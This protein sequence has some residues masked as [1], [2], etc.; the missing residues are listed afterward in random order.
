MDVKKVPILPTLVTLANAFCGFAAIIYI[1]QA[2]MSGADQAAVYMKYAGW[3]IILA[4]VFDALDGKVARL[5]NQTSE[6][7]VQLDSLSDMISFGVAPAVMVKAIADMQ[8]FYP[9]AAWITGA[10]FMMCAA[11][12]LA[13]FN[14]DTDEED[15]HHFFRGLPSPAAGGFIASLAVLNF[16]LRSDADFT[17]IAVA[18]EPIMDGL[19]FSVPFLAAI[20]ALLMISNIRYP[21]IASRL[22]RG[23]EPFDYLVRIILIGLFVLLTRPFSLPIFF[24]LYVSMGVV[25]AVKELFFNRMWPGKK[26]EPSP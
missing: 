11:L 15:S 24:G 3:L 16:S 22:L 12:R 18:L 6:F 8:N 9:R 17:R 14:V 25:L 10:L 7:G 20:L 23:N 19:L 21:H 26:G 4:I 1:I 5:A 13:R 2:R